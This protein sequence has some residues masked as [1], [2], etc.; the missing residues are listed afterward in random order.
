MAR[1]YA[2][3]TGL[4]PYKLKDKF[5]PINNSSLHGTVKF[6]CENNDLQSIADNAEYID[7]SSDKYFSE[8]FIENVRF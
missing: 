5:I 8:L 4:I 7:L 2:V 1:A 3:K 6:V